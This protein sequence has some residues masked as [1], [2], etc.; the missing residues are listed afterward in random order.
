MSESV[1]CIIPFYNE[2]INISSVLNVVNKINR[3]GQI[4]CIDDGSTD[5]SAGV[6]QQDFPET[7]LIRLKSNLGKTSAIKEGL[8][9]VKTDYVLLLDADLTDLDKN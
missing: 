3:I 6:V 7:E 9:Y 2:E 5:G 1:D 4:L 8:K